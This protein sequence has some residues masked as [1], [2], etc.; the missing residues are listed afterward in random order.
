ML[1]VNCKYCCSESPRVALQT[2]PQ[3]GQDFSH[4]PT[5][6]PKISATWVRI[7]SIHGLPIFCINW[8]YFV[9]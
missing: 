3:P 8:H 9:F 4:A 5:K 7:K 6:G 2:C 1:H